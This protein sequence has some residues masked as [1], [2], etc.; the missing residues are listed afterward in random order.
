[1]QGQQTELQG[2]IRIIVSLRQRRC[3]LHPSC[4]HTRGSHKAYSQTEL[5]SPPPRPGAKL[6]PSSVS[7]SQGQCPG[8]PAPHRGCTQ[9]P[10]L[11]NAYAARSGTP[12]QTL[13]RDRR[14]AEPR[15]A[16]KT[17]EWEDLPEPEFY[18]W[19]PI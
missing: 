2:S 16:M 4:G 11:I 13:A 15:R 18:H 8:L 19:F 3:R 10:S 7:P 9:P 1:M 17:R 12:Q 14:G 6:S 5:A